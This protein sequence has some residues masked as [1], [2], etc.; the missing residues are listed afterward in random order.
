MPTRTF[1][2]KKEAHVGRGLVGSSKPLGACLVCLGRG[3]MSAHSILLALLQTMPLCIS[4]G[5]MHILLLAFLPFTAFHALLPHFQPP[6]V[7][8]QNAFDPVLR[9]SS[10]YSVTQGVY[11]YARTER[12]RTD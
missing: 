5:D 4:L 9:L 10:A 12:A 8:P 1:L 11:M 6:K 7:G 2:S 3:I